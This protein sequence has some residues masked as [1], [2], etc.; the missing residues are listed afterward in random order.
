MYLSVS[1]RPEIVYAVENL[2]RFSPK[3]NKEH[4]TALKRVLRYLKETIKNGILYSQTKS[5]ECACFSDADWAGDINDRKSNL[6]AYFRLVEQL[7][8]REAKARVCCTEAEYIALS[9][10]AQESIWLRCLTFI[11]HLQPSMKT[12]CNCHDQES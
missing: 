11:R 2:A 9:S 3:P 6:D 8:P 4:W 7:P 5:G 1:T 10:A 12:I